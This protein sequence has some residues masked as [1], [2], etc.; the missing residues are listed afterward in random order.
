M[1]WTEPAEVDRGA[2]HLLL[3]DHYLLQT[4]PFKVW[5][6]LNLPLA[7]GA[8]GLEG[9]TV[10][11]VTHRRIEESLRGNNPEVREE[12]KS[13]FY[14]TISAIAPTGKPCGKNSLARGAHLEIRKCYVGGASN[15]VET[16]E[17]ERSA[18]PILN[19]RFEY[20]P[21]TDS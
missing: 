9:A 10:Y 1:I 8:A 21:A 11:H 7:P 5:S 16:G 14:G 13:R 4:T 3:R 20:S 19:Y 2:T 18:S 12:G 6:M 15:G 17:V